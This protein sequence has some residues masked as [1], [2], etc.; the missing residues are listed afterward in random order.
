MIKEVILKTAGM[1]DSHN[2]NESDLELWKSIAEYMNGESA[3]VVDHYTEDGTFT[4]FCLKD[5][6]KD[7]ELAYMKEQDS[8]MGCYIDDRERFN[9]DWDREEYEADGL[10]LLLKENVI[11]PESQESYKP[12][13]LPGQ[14]EEEKDV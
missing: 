4:F 3:L 12:Y 2:P 5:E 13:K 9:E 8:M 6:T 7:K 1:Y 10:F 14:Q 11:I